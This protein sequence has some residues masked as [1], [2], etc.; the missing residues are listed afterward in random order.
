MQYT[1]TKNSKIFHADSTYMQS[2][3]GA[4][5]GDLDV[6][7]D[8]EQDE[9]LE[10]LDWDQE[11]DGWSDEFW[12]DI[13]TTRD[14]R[15]LAVVA[16]D[17]WGQPGTY[18]HAVLEIQRAGSCRGCEI[19]NSDPTRDDFLCETCVSHEENCKESDYEEACE[20]FSR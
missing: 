14:G 8:N 19:N 18:Y 10:I 1:P 16:D 2:E 6:E 4:Q 12:A 11:K 7:F 20:K 5:M 3:Y 15:L 9:A 17:A 13:V